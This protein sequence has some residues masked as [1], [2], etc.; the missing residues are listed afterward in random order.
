MV[1]L[2]TLDGDTERT[3]RDAAIRFRYEHHLGTGPIKDVTDLVQATVSADVTLLELPDGIDSLMY[4]DDVAHAV[5]I[6]VGTSQNPER[7]R[8]SVAHELGHWV[9]NEL[10]AHADSTPN[11]DAEHRAHAFARHLLLPLDAIASHFEAKG[12]TVVTER[13][14]SDLVSLY[15]VSGTVA[16]IQ[17]FNAG[18]IDAD[19][20]QEWEYMDA[21]YLARRYGWAAERDTRVLDSSKPRPPQRMLANAIDAYVEHYLSVETLALVSGS[22]T[23]SELQATL[24]AD[25]VRPRPVNPDPI[26]YDDFGSGG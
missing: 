22:V 15:E 16:A 7:Q 25:G 3:G 18:L 12:G 17:L 10:T 14:L 2:S 8:F 1:D 21:G 11:P 9:L 26:D 23:A 4:S 24:D 5:L 19:R 13:D 6:A 20:F